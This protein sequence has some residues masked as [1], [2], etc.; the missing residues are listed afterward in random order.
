MS[1]R[2]NGQR[3]LDAIENQIR[4]EEPQLTDYFSAFGSTVPLIKPVRGWDRAASSKRTA[5][6]GRHRPAGRRRYGQVL[7]IIATVLVPVVLVAGTMWW[8]IAALSAP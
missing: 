6:R 5:D 1:L 8:I 3:I 2:D 7:I 4:A